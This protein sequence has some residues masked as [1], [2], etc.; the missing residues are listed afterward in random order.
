[1]EATMTMSSE[2]PIDVSPVRSTTTA[3]PENRLKDRIA[4]RAGRPLDH[5]LLRPPADIAMSRLEF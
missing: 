4:M 1:M 3:T 2:L 5:R